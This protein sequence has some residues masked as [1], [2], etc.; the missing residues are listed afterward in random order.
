MENFT[1]Q[2]Y[3]AGHQQALADYGMDKEAWAKGLE[4]WN[5]ARAGATAGGSAIGGMLQRG[6]QNVGRAFKGTHQFKNTEG[7]MNRMGQ[8]MRSGGRGFTEL[9]KTNPAAAAALAGTG[10]AGTAGL[11]YAMA[12]GQ[13]PQGLSM[14]YLG[15]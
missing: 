4:L 12:P 10:V 5:K 13:K 15:L 6:A 7:A 11:G 3:Y 9:A 8:L 14:K 2:A 1:K